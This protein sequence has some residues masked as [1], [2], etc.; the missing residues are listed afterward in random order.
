MTAFNIVNMTS[1]E[2]LGRYYAVNV[3]EALNAMARYAGYADFSHACEAV[4]A[5]R[6]EVSITEL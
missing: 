3:S 1:G 2:E 6:T 5:I 4:P